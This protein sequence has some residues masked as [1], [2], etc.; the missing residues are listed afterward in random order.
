MNQINGYLHLHSSHSYDGK[1]SLPEIKEKCLALG[2]SFVAMA[3]HIDG[4]APN[5]IQSAAS[6]CRA[7]SDSKFVFMPGFELPYKDCHVL[8]LGATD[9]RLDLPPLEAIKL[10][11]Q[12]G[13]F[14][15]LAHP[16]RNHYQIDQELLELLDGIE[17]WNQQYDGKRYP[18]IQALELFEKNSAQRTSLLAAAGLDFH[19]VSHFGNPRIKLDVSEI[20]EKEIINQLKTGNY[21]M[22]SK[23]VSL[24][25]R[26]KLVGLQR[27]KVGFMSRL[28]C[29]A[30]AL[31]KS[32][33]KWLYEHNLAM[34]KRLKET[35]RK[36]L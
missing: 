17:V 15:V 1:L 8:L 33:N 22:L 18:R 34:P 16:H 24:S 36:R 28:S 26:P 35:I 20:S 14:I 2:M 4:L 25:S 30:I 21:S 5:D 19:R 27:F 23:A 7:L 6:E 11:K 13:A 10:A 3:E 29:G 12:Q 9:V 31:G 32:V